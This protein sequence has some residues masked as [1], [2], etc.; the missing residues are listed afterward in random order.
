MIASQKSGWSL[1][2]KTWH[3][4]E[5]LTFDNPGCKQSGFGQLVGELLFLE[6]RLMSS[7]HPVLLGKNHNGRGDWLNFW[8]RTNQKTSEK[9]LEKTQT[10]I[11]EFGKKHILSGLTINYGAHNQQRILQNTAVAFSIPLGA[12]NSPPPWICNVRA[13]VCICIC[14]FV[15]YDRGGVFWVSSTHTT[16]NNA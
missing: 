12:I 16:I 5:D 1:V 6:G 3:N 2:L 11:L 9:Y 4:F 7:C 13:G 15:M 8:K 14:E 10:Y